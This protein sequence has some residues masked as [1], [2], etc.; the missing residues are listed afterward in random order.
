MTWHANLKLEAKVQNAIDRWKVELE[1]FSLTDRSVA[2]YGYLPS[3]SR[4][5]LGV[6][7]ENR[8]LRRVDEIIDEYLAEADPILAAELLNDVDAILDELTSFKLQ[9]GL[10]FE[11]DGKKANS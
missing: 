9:F 5:L 4:I 6:V 3:G 1:V 7:E 8:C 10:R 2:C 11:Q